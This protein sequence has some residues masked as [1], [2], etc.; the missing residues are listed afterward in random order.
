MY[1]M[2]GRITIPGVPVEVGHMKNGMT[3]IVIT[4]LEF[5]YKSWPQPSQYSQCLG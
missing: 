2:L 1:M 3:V 5:L 4:S